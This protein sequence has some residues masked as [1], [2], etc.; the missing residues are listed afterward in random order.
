MMFLPL[1]PGDA[2]VWE[3]KLLSSTQT[4]IYSTDRGRVSLPNLPTWRQKIL[5]VG[6]E[7]FGK[8]T[9]CS[10]LLRLRSAVVIE[11]TFERPLGASTGSTAK[12]RN[13]S[14]SLF[15]DL[16]NF[17]TVRLRYGCGLLLVLGY[18]GQS[19]LIWPWKYLIIM[20]CL[21]PCIWTGNSFKSS[22]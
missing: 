20:F 1:L 13:C 15:L 7:E 21:C 10:T 8:S 16:I 6:A 3:W 22:F 19:G 11:V 2:S 4:V 18:F 5:R 12:V 17:N 14:T 9:H